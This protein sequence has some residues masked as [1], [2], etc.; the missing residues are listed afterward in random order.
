L[1]AKKNYEISMKNIEYLSGG[2]TINWGKILSLP[3]DAAR[4]I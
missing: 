3:L 4:D 1:N 2:L